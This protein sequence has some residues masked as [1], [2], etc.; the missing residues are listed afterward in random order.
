MPGPAWARVAT[1]LV[2]VAGLV[3]FVAAFWWGLVVVALLALVLL[4]LVVPRVLRLPGELQAATGATLV[5]GAW[6][7]TL[8]WYVVVPWL[9]IVVHAVANGLLA[10]VALELVR[11]AGYLPRRLPAGGVASCGSTW[12]RASW[13]PSCSSG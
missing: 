1:D 2:A 9:D 4:G 10:A 11:R 7:A 8:D 6:G 12:S 3:S 13:S 5:L